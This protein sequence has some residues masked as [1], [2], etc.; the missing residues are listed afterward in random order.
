[1]RPENPQCVAAVRLGS[2]LFVKGFDSKRRGIGLFTFRVRGGSFWILNADTRIQTC[3]PLLLPLVMLS[4]FFLRFTFESE[5]EEKKK[6]ANEGK[7]N[8]S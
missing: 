1:M 4:I 3:F 2:I 8:R 6:E 7:G 5:E